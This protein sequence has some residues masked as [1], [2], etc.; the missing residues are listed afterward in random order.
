MSPD[1]HCRP[2]DEQAGGTILGQGAGVVLLK[3]LDD[4]LRDNDHIY[5]VIK[6]SGINND[7]SAKS[8]Y[9]APSIEGQAKAIML[10]QASADVSP[11]QIGY[12]EAHGT[13]TPLG[14]PI[15][16]EGLNYAFN[17]TAQ[18]LDKIED[19]KH[20]SC[21]VG[22]VKGNV[23]H[24]DAA[25][26]VAG[27]IKATKALELKT[28]PPMINF[29]KANPKINFDKTP[30][31]VNTELKEWPEKLGG[32][33]AGVSSFGIGGTNAHIVLG[34]APS[35]TESS[36]SRPWHILTL[37]AKTDTA[38]DMRTQQ[39]L[40][41]LSDNPNVNF[42]D[43]CYSLHTG[44]KRHEHRRYLVCRNA[45]DAILELSK[46]DTS[47]SSR[48]VTT[49][50]QK[51]NRKLAFMFTGQGSQYVNMARTLY[52][53][54][55][56]FRRVVDHCRTILR[57][58][59]VF[60]FERLVEDDFSALSDKVHDTYIT[61]P[62]LFITEYALAKMLMSWNIEPDLMLG[63]SIGEYVAATLAGVF[64]LDQA[65]E[66]VTIR[67]RMIY[68]LEKGDMMMVGLSEADIQEYLSEQVSLAAVNGEKRCVVSGQSDAILAL[69]KTLKAQEID[70]RILHTSH[71]FH[72]HMMDDIL[73]DF[74]NS[75]RKRQPREPQVPFVSTMTG[76]MIT[77]EQA[78]SPEYWAQHLR[79][80]VRFHQGMSTLLNQRESEDSGWILMEIGPG[81]V[82]STLTRQHPERKKQDI[83]LETMRQS[84]EDVSDTF[85]LLNTIAKLWMHNV[86]IDWEVYHSNRQRYK[87]PLPTYP[88][89]RLDY[90]IESGKKLRMTQDRR[91]QSYD[92]L[93][94][95][96]VEKTEVKATPVPSV[97]ARNEVDRFICQLWEKTL[98]VDKIGI[99]DNYFD[100]GGD[101]LRAVSIVDS[102]VTEFKAPI[103]THILI[104]KPTVA[105]LS[106][107]IKSITQHPEVADMANSDIRYTESLVT[108]QKGSDRKQPLFMVHP[109]GGEV[110][111]YRDLAHQL[112]ADQPLFA[113]QA[114]SLAG[115]SEP[116]NDV[117]AMAADYISELKVIGAKPPYL[118][119]GSSFGGLVAY[120]MAQ[121]L[122]ALGEEV[123]LLVMIDTPFPQEMPAHLTNSAA[124]LDYLLKDKIPLSL[125]RL[126]KLEPK[127]Q[128]DYV[129]SEARTRG[130]SDIIPPHLGVPLFNTW[131]A[132]QEATFS[133]QP[134]NYADDV[135]FFRHT[136]KMEHFPSAPHE[137]W[138][139]Y[140][141]GKVEIHQVPGNH[142][143]M[144][145]H[146]C[147]N[148]LAAHLKVVLKNT[149]DAIQRDKDEAEANK[150]YPQSYE[151]D[152][153]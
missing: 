152:V 110:Y 39:L 121:Q 8:G 131:I 113:F 61:Q 59:F 16:I 125:E 91:G 52:R 22:S 80:C 136:E 65:L 87:I 68:D 137:T 85:K 30:F 104:Q 5:A 44:R 23:G 138:L 147:V 153:A 66:L 11:D 35:K 57:E 112:G 135:V 62:T 31:Y 34:E 26:G 60:L 130:K 84:D 105:M 28:L 81:K 67:G 40:G 143:T 94:P 64:T 56:S 12:I 73:E 129:L 78:T 128:I 69:Q 150:L 51:I 49:Q 123:R 18:S 145:Y 4:A 118:L 25:S 14:D 132:H 6:G 108:I 71:A 74:T 114:T 32:R 90:W 79:N 139:D 58:K 83:V 117:A 72:S 124:I 37:S 24:M 141:E 77:N 10:A 2:F 41:F 97:E 146:P 76:K 20:A 29:S 55:L 9:T 1:G 96:P 106:D 142:I 134:K 19:L 120:E 13:G 89:E 42:S 3:R 133:Y 101:S 53:V 126:N 119:G 102:L 103:P 7:G 38:L 33:H 70:N 144:N 86:E 122:K 140:I 63:H 116:Y 109:I 107:H 27:L 50:N 100:L 95:L 54:E 93:P 149:A 15:E 115:Q 45:D 82:L 111:F 98:G 148:V 75:V 47:A 48:I 99:N 21:A 92:Q 17:T 46:P 36:S 127:D 151:V 43:V 88:F